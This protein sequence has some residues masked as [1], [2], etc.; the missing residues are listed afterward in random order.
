MNFYKSYILNFKKLQYVYLPNT[1]MILLSS[2][3]NSLL[4]FS[5]ILSLVSLIFSV[6]SNISSLKSEVLLEFVLDLDKILSIITLVSSYK[7]SNGLLAST[8]NIY[9]IF[10]FI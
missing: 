7:L 9:N 1:N 8:L 5:V 2:F 3:N 4:L 6:L 10:Y